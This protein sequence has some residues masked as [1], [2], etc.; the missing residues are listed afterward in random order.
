MFCTVKPVREKKTA[1]KPKY[2]ELLIADMGDKEMTVKVNWPVLSCN[3]CA[4]TDS[5][6]QFVHPMHVAE[7]TH[8][9]MFHLISVW[10][11]NQSRLDNLS[12]MR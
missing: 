3:V 7:E 5:K 1:Y 8:N 11:E 9:L 4:A 2:G 6:S 12:R 10:T